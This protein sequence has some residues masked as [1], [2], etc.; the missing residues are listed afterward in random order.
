MANQQAQQREKER[1]PFLH[2]DLAPPEKEPGRETYKVAA[3]IWL[4][5]W[6]GSSPRVQIRVDGALWQGQDFYPLD[7]QRCLTANITGLAVGVHTIVVVT[8][9]GRH[10]NMKPIN[11]PRPEE[12]P[13]KPAKIMVYESGSDGNYSLTFQ[14]LT[15]DDSPVPKAKVRIIDPDVPNRFYD[16]KPTDEKGVTKRKIQFTTPEKLLNVLV[17]GSSVSTWKNLFY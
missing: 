3:E 5:R 14:V 13:K 2:L 10:R 11:I 7:Q 12:K 1:E 4:S 6:T 9:D 16:L 17:L 8:E 15:E